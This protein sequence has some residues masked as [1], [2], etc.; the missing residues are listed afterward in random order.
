MVLLPSFLL[1]ACSEPHHP[2]REDSGGMPPGDTTV[3]SPEPIVKYVEVDARRLAYMTLGKGQPVVLVH[4]GSGDMRVWANQLKAFSTKYQVVA[5]SCRGYYP[6]EALHPHDTLTLDTLVHDLTG[7]IQSLNLGPVHLVGHSSPGGFASL[8]LARRHPELLR[9]LV[10]IE[11]PAFPLLG[12]SIPPKFSQIA[13]LMFRQPR[14][15]IGFL[16]FGAKGLRPALN[17]FQE[18]DDSE[19]LRLFMKANLGAAAF[20][21][22]SASRF[23]QAMENIE[24][25]KAQIRAGFPHFSAADAHRIQVPTLLVSGEKSNVV[26]HAVTDKL[27]ALLPHVESVTIKGASHNMFETNPQAFNRAVIDFLDRHRG[28]T[29]H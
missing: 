2:D 13:G 10:L 24:P 28:E 12:V 16:R 19:G 3:G 26:L 11:P 21:Q 1:T 20:N 18:G 15:A 4:G 29:G 8:L 6:S 7:F 23:D 14:V 5:V 17:A 22:L 9:S 25:L 27:R